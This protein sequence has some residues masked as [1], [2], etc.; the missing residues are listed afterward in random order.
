MK[1]TTDQEIRSAFHAKKLASHHNNHDTIVIDELGVAHGKNRI[2]IAVV[3]GFIHGYEIKS[4]KD[5]LSRFSLQLESYMQCFE[6]LSFIAAEK[7]IEDI[8]YQTPD[9]CGII[10]VEKG[11]RGGINFTTIRKEKRNPDISPFA[12][13]HFLWKNEAIGI[14][15]SLGADKSMLKGTRATIY[16][17]LSHM[18]TVPE[19]SA[20]IKMF[21]MSREEWRAVQQ[22][23]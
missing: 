21:F 1:E 10:L 18:I 4:S 15:K 3:N 16:K 5:T 22:P 8:V 23:K 13:A 14:L 19:L 9:W 7:H 12:M 20:K 11:P 17:H 2:D 6:K